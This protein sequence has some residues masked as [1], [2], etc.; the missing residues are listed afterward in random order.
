DPLPHCDPQGRVLSG[1]YCP[2][3]TTF[4]NEHAVTRHVFTLHKQ[5]HRIGV[6]IRTLPLFDGNDVL[7]GAAIAF[8]Q[9]SASLAD[10]FAG[11]LMFGCLDPITG[12]PTQRLTRAVVL[13]SLAGLHES[14]KGFGLLR[15]CMR[16][17]HE[18]TAKYGADSMVAILH[19]AAQTLRHSMDPASFLGRW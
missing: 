13:E 5:G 8:E 2:V 4:L 12:V 9:A 7:Q 14:H 17:L 16:G 18:L 6:L 19:T 15:I 10:E 3:T 11:A 1:N